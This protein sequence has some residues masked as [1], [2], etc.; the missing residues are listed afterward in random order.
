[1]LEEWMQDAKCANDPDLQ[2]NLQD[3][4]SGFYVDPFFDMTQTQAHSKKM[5]A[6]CSTCPVKLKCDLCAEKLHAES[7]YRVTGYWGGISPK[8]R[9]NR[10]TKKKK[11]QQ[12][13]EETARLLLE[14]MKEQFPDSDN[15]IAS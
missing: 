8:K 10:R 15:P 7:M 6:Y 5:A 4:R 12:K 2:A 9:T 11:T 1:M 14:Q 13:F 3:V